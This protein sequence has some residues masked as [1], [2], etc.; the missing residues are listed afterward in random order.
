M[1]AYTSSRLFLS[2]PLS[3]NDAGVKQPKAMRLYESA[4]YRWIAAFGDCIGNP[5]SV[6]FEK[7]LV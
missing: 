7:K 1:S 4:G 3:D 2:D 6:C 5:L